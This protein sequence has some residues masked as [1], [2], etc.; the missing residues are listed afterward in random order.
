MSV[1]W[2]ANAVKSICNSPSSKHCVKLVIILFS[3]A[4]SVSNISGKSMTLPKA[5]RKPSGRETRWT[6]ARCVFRF[7]L[8]CFI[9]GELMRAATGTRTRRSLLAEKANSKKRRYVIKSFAQGNDRRVIPILR[10][11]WALLEW[12][13]STIYVFF[14]VGVFGLRSVFLY[15]L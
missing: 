5:R 9:P 4:C 8:A 14:A 13:Q 6:R 11:S 2:P 12:S 1:A 3:A 10:A 7:A 15:V